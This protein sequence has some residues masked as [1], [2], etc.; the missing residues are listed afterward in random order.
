MHG[1]LC[2]EI[3]RTSQS[4]FEIEYVTMYSCISNSIGR[5]DVSDTKRLIVE[6][7]LIRY[8]FDIGIVFASFFT[9]FLLS[10]LVE[11]TEVDELSYINVI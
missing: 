7:A 11:A 4:I 5:Q 10:S 9:I 3:T 1:L 8:R 2:I 6:N